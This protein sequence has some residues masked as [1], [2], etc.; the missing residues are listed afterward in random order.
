M[1]P[2][3][4]GFEFAKLS[5]GG[6]DFIIIDSRTKP[7]PEFVAEFVRKAC[8]RRE[9]IGADGMIYLLEDKH[10]PF[11]ISLFNSDGSAAAVSYNGS[12]CVGR[13]AIDSGLC[14]SP[15]VFASEAGPVEVSAEGA[16]ISLTVPPPGE[17]RLDFE[18]EH[19]GEKF[20]ANHIVAGVPY[21]VLFRDSLESGWVECIPPQLK[22]HPAFPGGTNV[23]VVKR[24]GEKN[25]RAR[26]FERGVKEETPSSGSGSVAVALISAL[27]WNLNAPISVQ[28]AGG[29][30]IIDF[31]M[32]E[33]TF[34]TIITAGEV[35]Y[36]FSGRL[37]DPLLEV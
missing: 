36:L 8:D 3:S 28:T 20:R 25:F 33:G 12:R 21:L 5:C 18:L 31:E 37:H 13:F 16:R 34:H 29:T 23:A 27:I 32:S 35:V 14:P 7:L 30:F 17:C 2:S 22:T 4:T 10:Y 9:G 1:N 6:N 26:F 19:D 11:C 24:D 15:F